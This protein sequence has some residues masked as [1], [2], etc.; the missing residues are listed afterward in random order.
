MKRLCFGT[1]M[2]ILYQARNQ[3]VT[4][5]LLCDAIFSSYAQSI[6]LRDGS[7]PGHLKSGRDNVPPDV[8]DAARNT[9]FEDA[10]KVFQTKVISLIKDSKRE[11]VVRAIKDVLREDTTIQDH[12]VVGY[13][14]GYEK[15]NILINSTFSLSALLAS[16]FYFAII[17][18]KNQ[19]CKDAIKEIS[20]NCN[21]KLNTRRTFMQ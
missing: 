10:E 2:S 4:N 12:T 8:I 16:V 18:V 9:S 21:N 7:L 13:I 15:N 19:E 17:E 14:N 6:E 5:N 11:S 3:K 1:L 20:P